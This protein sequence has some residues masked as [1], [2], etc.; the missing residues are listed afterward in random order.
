MPN[1]AENGRTAAARSSIFNTTERGRFI[2]LQ[3]TYALTPNGPVGPKRL[4]GVAVAFVC[5]LFFGIGLA[6]LMGQLDDAVYSPDELEKLL[7]IPLLAT[8]PPAGKLRDRFALNVVSLQKRNGHLNGSSALLV[9]AE[10]LSPFSEAYRKLRTLLLKTAVG[11]RPKT[12]LIT[13]SIP[14]EPKNCS[15]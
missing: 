14:S 15:P 6:L 5:S 12:V 4:L 11:T 3:V 13:S 9:N 7:D 2:I 8:I 1:A 10:V